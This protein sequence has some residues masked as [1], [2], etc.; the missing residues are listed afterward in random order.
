LQRSFEINAL[1]RAFQLKQPSSCRIVHALKTG[2][3]MQ[4]KR[5]KDFQEQLK[6]FLK[7]Y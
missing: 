2:N 4:H 1:L 6:G 5:G 7:N 3:G